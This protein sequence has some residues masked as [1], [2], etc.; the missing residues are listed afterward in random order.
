M[1]G[2]TRESETG[3]AWRGEICVLMKLAE[4]VGGKSKSLKPHQNAAGTAG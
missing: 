2:R 4:G 1:I 3:D